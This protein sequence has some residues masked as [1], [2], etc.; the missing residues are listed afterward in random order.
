MA[1]M[2]ITICG[3]NGIH[4]VE[5]EDDDCEKFAE[6][7]E[8]WAAGTV[9]GEPVAEYDIT[10][11]N[12]SK[13]YAEQAGES[14]TIA[15]ESAQI[16]SGAEINAQG[17]AQQAQEAAGQIISTEKHVFRQTYTTSGETSTL[18][19]NPLGYTY[20]SRDVCAVYISGLKLNDSEFACADGVVTLETPVTHDG[21]VIEVVVDTYKPFR[22]T[23]FA[24]ATV[25][26]ASAS[27][28]NDTQTVTVEGVTASN[29]VFVSPVPSDIQD[30]VGAGIYCSAQSAN[31]LTF[32]KTGSVTADIDVNVFVVDGGIE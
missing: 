31:S 32:T 25:T 24:E 4:M 29:P 22:D 2:S 28:S 21:T 1:D 18:T 14:A 6:D 17:Y 15:Q 7:A 16:A 20:D 3:K 26:L 27:W 12:N 9:N 10:Y 5:C 23:F 19:F 30:Y 13:Y 8:K 11:H